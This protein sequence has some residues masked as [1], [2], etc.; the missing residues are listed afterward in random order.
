MVFLGI[1]I[2]TDRMVLE[3]APDRLQ[4]LHKLLQCWLSKTSA[5]KK[6]TQSLIGVL[7]FMAICIKPGRVFM[8]R[9]LNFLRECPELGEALIP[10]EVKDDTN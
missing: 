2:D 8:A 9:L 5:S 7:Q 4:E 6:Q 10:E 1:L 3:V